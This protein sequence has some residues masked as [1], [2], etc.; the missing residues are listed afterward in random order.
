MLTNNFYKMAACLLFGK[1]GY[2]FTQS[3][4]NRDGGTVTTYPPM[5]QYVYCMQLSYIFT[6][7]GDGGST[8]CVFMGTGSEPPTADDYCLSGKVIKGFTSSKSVTVEEDD[9]GVAVTAVYTVT[10][11]GSSDF[12]VSEVGTFGPTFDTSG[13]SQSQFIMLDRTVLDSP[14]TV[15]AGGIGQVTYTIKIK[16]HD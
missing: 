11:T 7:L 9:D 2:Q 1:E 16:T 13:Y 6:R 5:T 8:Q 10:N 3:V 15:P 12:T 14:V 4:V